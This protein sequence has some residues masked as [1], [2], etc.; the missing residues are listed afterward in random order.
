M[1]RDFKITLIG[2][3]T[4][5][6]GFILWTHF[7]ASGRKLS[8]SG[9]FYFYASKQFFANLVVTKATNGLH[10]TSANKSIGCWKN[11]DSAGFP[12][13][14]VEV[15]CTDFVSSNHEEI[16]CMYPDMWTS[17]GFRILNVTNETMWVEYRMQIEGID[18]NREDIG[19][20]YVPLAP[21]TQSSPR[22]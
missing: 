22:D 19:Q 10:F 17:I 3:F 15:W 7:A 4:L 1:S 2:I 9:S 14:I 18:R 21:A 11:D 5:V 6:C 13:G 20:F 16:L 12:K 8:T